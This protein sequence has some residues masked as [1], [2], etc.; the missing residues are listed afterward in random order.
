MLIN[1]SL[2]LYMNTC[3]P[4]QFFLEKASIFFKLNMAKYVTGLISQM[5]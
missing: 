2:V 3:D 1:A 5:M 4:K